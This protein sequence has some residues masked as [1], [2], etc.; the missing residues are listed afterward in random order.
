[1]SKRPDYGDATAEDLARVLLHPINPEAR[2]RQMDPQP[3]SDEEAPKS[4]DIEAA[5]ALNRRLVHDPKTC[6]FCLDEHLPDP[7]GAAVV[8]DTLDWLRE[9]S[10]A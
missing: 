6:K 8:A 9:N 2:S 10:L 5:A 7:E 4:P 1:M 3:P